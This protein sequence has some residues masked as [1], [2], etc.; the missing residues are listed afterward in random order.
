MVVVV[1]ARRSPPCLVRTVL[2]RLPNLSTNCMLSSARVQNRCASS[3]ENRGEAI[4]FRET[5]PE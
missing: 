4:Q 1:V 2:L 5:S 3:D